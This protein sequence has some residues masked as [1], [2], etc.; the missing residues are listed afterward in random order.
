MVDVKLNYSNRYEDTLASDIL[1]TDIFKS[2]VKKQSAALRMFKGLWT[3]R[4][5]I[6]KQD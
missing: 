5:K 2:D 6:M 4:K 3:E 1:Y